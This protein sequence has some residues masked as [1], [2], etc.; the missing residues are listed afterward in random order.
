MQNLPSTL[1]SIFLSSQSASIWIPLVIT[2]LSCPLLIRW[3]PAMR[4]FDSPSESSRKIHHQ[5]KPLG[6]AALLFGFIPVILLYGVTPLSLVIAVLIVFLTGLFDD[7]S[8]FDPK[9]KL[10][11]QIVAATVLVTSHP[12]PATNFHLV[13]DLKISLSGIPN[14]VF[15]GFWLVGGTNAFNLIDGLDG[16][17][18]G[19][20]IISLLPLITFTFG[21]GSY[22]LPAGLAAALVAIL[23]Y[24]F[25]PARLFLGDG[26]SYLVGFLASY[27][28]I[29]TLS[30]ISGAT[31]GWN[32]G[33]GIL[34]IGVPILDTVLAIFRRTGSK[35]GIM[36]A[37]QDHLHHK[38][39]RKFG[40]VTAV[41]MV[42]LIQAVLSGLAL[43]VILYTG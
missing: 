25:Y 11:L 27:L 31:A 43:L 8:G 18:A 29:N 21:Q 33:V 38:L 10:F 15:V 12:L 37:D 40:H 22:L 2:G 1:K 3:A 16:L 6:G 4:L 5:V 42:Y 26:G 34:L 24:N 30:S 17:A 35:K 20:G 32:L 28:V 19:I 9:S 7:I 36:E 23:V 41:L 39:Y 14:M 13:A